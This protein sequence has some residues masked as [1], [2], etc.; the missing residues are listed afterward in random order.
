MCISENGIGR[1]AQSRRDSIIARAGPVKKVAEA[2]VVGRISSFKKSFTPSA[3][4]C[5]SPY[6]PVILGPF[7]SC[8]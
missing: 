5:R 8:I 7:R 3:A 6:G 4:G 2:E 1:G